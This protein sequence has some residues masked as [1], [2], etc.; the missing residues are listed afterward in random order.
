MVTVG[1]VVAPLARGGVSQGEIGSLAVRRFA[2]ALYL[3]GE[4]GRAHV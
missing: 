3:L 4:I 1:W 2:F